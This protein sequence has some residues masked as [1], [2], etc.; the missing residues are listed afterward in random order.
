MRKLH[1]ELHVN[2]H[3]TARYM[4]YNKHILYS[5]ATLSLID[6]L[7]WQSCFGP[8]YVLLTHQ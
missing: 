7:L 2:M 8:T 1:P 5:H 4:Y 6:A 3:P